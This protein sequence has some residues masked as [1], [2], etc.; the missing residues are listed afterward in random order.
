M[1]WFPMMGSESGAGAG[2]S[3]KIQAIEVGVFLFLILSSMGS[4]YGLMGETSPG[5]VAMAVSVI[6]TDLALLTLVFYFVW[7][8]DESF[9]RIGWHVGK[10]WREIGW[11]LL[12]FLPVTFGLNVLAYVL[13]AAGV[14]ERPL[15]SF[16]TIQGYLNIL[17]ALVLTS[18]VAVA[19]ETIFRGYLILR[20]QTVT[21]NTAV[22]VLLATAIFSFGHIYEGA[23]G[24]L[25]VFFLGLV[26]AW[27]YLWRGSLIAPVIL[28]FLQDFISI[29]GQ[30]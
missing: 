3:R 16:L 5:F 22:A 17:L 26:F 8:N 15:P 13:R 23:A 1:V 29:V 6:F 14:A 20:L 11:G 7:R 4:A 10:G 21:G 30:R 2:P 27:I 24:L 19:E 12:L 25:G 28:H 9:Q 18:V